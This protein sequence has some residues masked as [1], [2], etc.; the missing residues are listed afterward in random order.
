[1]GD[2]ARKLVL[3]P[4]ESEHAGAP[5]LTQRWRQRARE[6]VIVD[7]KCLQLRPLLTKRGGQS[8]VHWS[9]GHGANST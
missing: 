1:M 3:R 6:E 7:L 9:C 2:G 5:V 4:A 8:A